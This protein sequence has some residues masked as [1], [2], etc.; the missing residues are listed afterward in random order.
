MVQRLCLILLLVVLP[1]G[2]AA[3][4]L[5]DL[6]PTR[7]LPDAILLDAELQPLD[8]PN[9][10]LTVAYGGETPHGIFLYIKAG[11]LR[12]HIVTVEFT[13]ADGAAIPGLPSERIVLRDTDQLLQLTLEAPPAPPAIAAE[14]AY[15]RLIASFRGGGRD[16]MR[17]YFPHQ[18]NWVSA[19]PVIRAEP[20]GEAVALLRRLA[21]QQRLPART[22]TV[23]PDSAVTLDPAINLSPEVVE[24]LR[25]ANPQIRPQF[26]PFLV[27]SQVDAMRRIELPQRFER[28]EA[29]EPVVEMRSIDLGTAATRI[30]AMR[31]Q[32]EIVLA[33]VPVADLKFIDP[34]AFTYVAPEPEETRPT[35]TDP[36]HQVAPSGPAIFSFVATE[37]EAQ[38]DLAEVLGIEPAILPDTNAASGVFYYVPSRYRLAYDRDLGGS[39]GLALRIDYD[40][41]EGGA[42]AQSVRVA[43]T[44][45]APLDGN[46]IAV[47]QA[48]L[49]AY[50][51]AHP[52]LHFAELRPLPLASVPEFAFGASLAGTVAEEDIAVTAFTDLLEGLQVTWRTDPVRA[53][54]IRRDLASEVTGIT[55]AARFAL[56]ST[57]P[58][59][60]LDVPAEVR[61]SNPELFDA[62]RFTRDGAVENVSPLPV[63]L[64][65]LNALVLADE[66]GPRVYS[67]RLDGTGVAPG[68]EAI[69]DLAEF[70]E[71]IDTIA[72]RIWLDYT[73]DPACTNCLAGIV[74]EVLAGGVWPDTETIEI[75]PL[76]SLFDAETVEVE[77]EVRSRFLDPTDRTLRTLPP[78]YLVAGEGSQFVGPVFP[79][80]PG[81][82]EAEGDPLIE[83]RLSALMQT[84]EMREGT[85]WLPFDRTR[86][87]PG[88]F[89]LEQ[90]LAEVEE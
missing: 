38:V 24:R 50:A 59:Q 23:P 7:D 51:E 46:S 18:R 70:P 48:L 8:A 78:L 34:Q 39:R 31:R 55:G 26:G 47:T 37:P 14:T 63:K 5:T 52:P 82:A 57:G 22:V 84:G 79:P 42:D 4:D 30:E 6:A 86:L 9:T 81:T 72:D 69:L 68:G 67:W 88:A 77:L 54:R 16:M 10:Y 45:Q 43:M 40:A 80:A 56:P 33:D 27:D 49:Q 41:V 25:V 71:Q 53:E 32:N 36:S 28:I 19:P 58:A 21:R 90:S 3:Q 66:G 20:V 1:V 85:V 13:D 75:A 62:V 35:S 29:V 74:E 65:W 17:L 73:L 76:D 89:Q 2:V 15:I 60:R 61:L 83:Y 64:T 11:G 12:G 44:L 87:R